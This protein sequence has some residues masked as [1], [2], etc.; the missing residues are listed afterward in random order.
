MI[1]SLGAFVVG[2]GLLL[3]CGALACASGR[4]QHPALVEATAGEESSAELVLIRMSE[5]AGGAFAMTLRLEGEKLA[6]LRTGRYVDFR[7][8]PGTYT[9]SMDP[10]QNIGGTELHGLELAPGTK[11]YVLLGSSDIV[12][13]YGVSVSISGG[14]NV[15]TSSASSASV[16]ALPVFGLQIIGEE[17]AKQLMSEYEAVGA[18]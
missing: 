6:K 12:W 17:T 15:P 5:L 3:A 18:D 13:G 10:F 1:R 7:L 11:T 9:L 14:V 16:S 8:Q 2:A 4:F